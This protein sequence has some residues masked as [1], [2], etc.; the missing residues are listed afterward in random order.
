MNPF[1]TFDKVY[2]IHLPHETNR[3]A[4]IEEQFN[5]VGILDRVTFIHAVPPPKNFAMSNMQSRGAAGNI[6]VNLS[7]IKAIVHA[8]SDGAQQP[9]FFEDDV[10]FNINAANMLSTA[11]AE[12]PTDWEMIYMGGHPRGPLNMSRAKKFSSSLAKVQRYSF[13][14]AYSMNR[15]CLLAFFDYWC[16]SITQEKAMYDILLGNFAATRKTYA[17]YP[18]ICTQR[19]GIS[20]ISLKHDDKSELIAR[21]WATHLGI[22]NVSEQDKALT[23]R[24]QRKTG[25]KLRQ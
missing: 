4:L 5:S 14:D 24:W 10:I 2:C 15:I 25:R 23:L 21:G 8:I 1:Q 17:T 16:N 22:K 13:A 19:P 18:I 11:L 6:G 12:L 3:R 7:Q 20:S 9:I